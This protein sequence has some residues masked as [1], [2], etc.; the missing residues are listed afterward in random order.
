[1]TSSRDGQVGP[2]G[3]VVVGRRPQRGFLGFAGDPEA[4][5]AEL[6]VAQV[7]ADTRVNPFDSDHA[8]ACS[9]PA[10]TPDTVATTR[11]TR[12]DHC[13]ACRCRAA[14]RPTTTRGSSAYGRVG[15]ASLHVAGDADGV[16][17]VVVRLTTEQREA[18]GGEHGLHPRDVVGTGARETMRARSDR[19]GDHL[20]RG[21]VIRTPTGE[22]VLEGSQEL[23]RSRRWRT[24]A[25]TAPGTRTAG[26]CTS[27]AASA[28]STRSISDE[29]S[30]GG[31]GRR[32]KSP[33]C[34]LTDRER[35]HDPR[36][37]RQVEDREARRHGRVVE[38]RLGRER[39]T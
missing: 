14:A 37:E 1:M 29:P 17:L 5:G 15:E 16:A 7:D 24:R 28:G 27:A 20:H 25:G 34:R 19:R 36:V 33:R 35:E 31:I 22:P 6:G 23:R 12:R 8:S 39:R 13:R 32:L 4:V 26:T 11:R 18:V 10:T 38:Q 3:R 2:G 9:R 21:A 30:S